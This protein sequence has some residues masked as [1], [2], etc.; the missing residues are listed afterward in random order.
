ME[1]TTIDQLLDDNE[2]TLSDPFCD[3]D[4]HANFTSRC[5][6][7]IIQCKINLMLIQ[8]D[9]YETIMRRHNL[10][11]NS[12]QEKLS[13]FNKTNPNMCTNLIMSAIE[14]RRQAMIKRFIRIR[15]HHLKTFFDEAPAVNNNHND[16]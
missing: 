6:K 12:F 4:Q 7:T 2:E 3:Q 16:N 14:E 8:L 1:Y 11:L 5:S 9:K 13:N 10:I 15:Q